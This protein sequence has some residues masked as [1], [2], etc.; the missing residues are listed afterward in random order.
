MKPRPI[1]VIKLAADPDRVAECVDLK[2]RGA[3]PFGEE[4]PALRE[5]AG[6]HVSNAAGRQEVGLVRATQSNNPPSKKAR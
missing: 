3:R 4:R 1:E 5:L 2:S 6:A